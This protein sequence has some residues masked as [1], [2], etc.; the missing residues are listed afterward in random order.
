MKVV[1]L[2]FLVAS[3]LSAAAYSIRTVEVFNSPCGPSLD[4]VTL[5][6][7]LGNTTTC[8]A[9]GSKILFVEKLYEIRETPSRNFFMV[10]NARDLLL[11]GN[12]SSV[13]CTTRPVGFAF[14]NVTNI[15]IRGLSFYGCG[16]VMP[17]LI[18]SQLHL[19]SANESA[20]FVSRGTQV[21]LLFGNANRLTLQS[22]S[23]CDSNGYG[24]VIVDSLGVQVNDSTFSRNNRQ[25][26]KCI[27]L[28]CCCGEGN[29]NGGNIVLI[30]T[31]RALSR[32]GNEFL[33]VNNTRITHGV[34]LDTQQ[35]FNENYAYTA[36][37][38]SIFSDHSLYN[39]SIVISHCT[40]A[41]NIGHSSGNAVIYI[42]DNIGSDYRINIIRTDFLDGNT[43]FERFQK[44]AKSGGLTIEYGYVDE[45]RRRTTYSGD[46]DFKR[47]FIQHST[48]RGNM[49]FTAGALLF[50]SHIVRDKKMNGIIRF[51]NC[52]ISGNFGYD[53]IITAHGNLGNRFYNLDLMMDGLR[54]LQNRI[55]PQV[56]LTDP[57]LAYHHFPHISSLHTEE[58]ST[59]TCRDIVI[60]GNELRGL[61]TIWNTQFR[62]QQENVISD[63]RGTEGGAIYVDSSLIR[64]HRSGARINIINNTATLSGG[65]IYVALAPPRLI[66][67]EQ[68]YCFFDVQ[69]GQCRELP[70]TLRGSILLRNNTAGVSGNS[71]YGGKVG[72]CML[73]ECFFEI[74]PNRLA[75]ISVFEIVF[76]LP[77]NDSLTEVTSDIEGLCFCIGGRPQ[78]D[79]RTWS[80][81]AYPG[82]RVKVPA[83][84]VGQLN[85]TNPAIVLSRVYGLNSTYIAEQE[86]RQQVGVDCQDLNY[87]IHS[88]ESTQFEI[89]LGVIT[90]GRV[91]ETDQAIV[92]NTTEC[93]KGFELMESQQCSC[94][95]FLQEHGVS[96]IL[97]E[98]S[99]KR[100]ADVWLRY[101]LQTG[102]F[103]AH[104]SCPLQKCTSE[105]L[106]LD[107]NSS[108]SPCHSEFSGILCGRCA[109]GL[110]ATLG[111][112]GC[113]KCAGGFSALVVLIFVIA[114]PLLI[115]AM[116]YGDLTV[117]HGTFNGIIFYANIVHIHR[118][119]LFGPDHS[120]PVTVLLAWLNL[121]LGIE[122]CFYPGM[123]FYAQMWFQFSFPVYILLLV[124]ILN[125]LNWYTIL[126]G[127]I[128]G[129]NIRSVEATLV[130]LSYTKLLRLAAKTLSYTA[131]SSSNGNKYKLWLYDGNLAFM[132]SKHAILAVSALAILIF[133]ILPF[134]LLMLLEYP[135]L[136]HKTRR[137]LVKS[138][139]YTSIHVFQ[140]PYN[141]ITR[142]WTG[143]LLLVRIL[144]V[145]FHQVNVVGGQELNFVIIVT[146]GLCGLGTMWNFGSLYRNKYVTA[147]ETFYIMNLVLLAGW[148][149][150]V[151][152]HRSQLILSYTLVTLSLVVFLSTIVYHTGAK[153]FRAVKGRKEIRKA[154]LGNR[155]ITMQLV[156]DSDGQAAG[157]AS[158][159]YIR[160]TGDQT[161]LSK[162]VGEGENK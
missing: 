124:L 74:T 34:N 25:V 156:E 21:A 76:D 158:H 40:V 68:T 160:V 110:S 75:G 69:Y 78:C 55:L 129:N 77:W 85:G 67:Q 46:I 144:L 10:V 89:K 103:L 116:L 128:I 61:S 95:S 131:I 12:N 33:V 143:V 82:M 117:N 43:R 1:M 4:C 119:I 104:K 30:N 102:E 36:G 42:H 90:N 29:C 24:V 115:A 27:N 35:N 17:D 86:V 14:I 13:T 142:W 64:L 31:D 26:L 52:S 18:Q 108:D 16:A 81:K 19:A 44:T 62:F 111:R 23:V 72:T 79:L 37:G 149:E 7:C 49:A 2:R 136:R 51:R 66:S 109:S 151:T 99:F 120:S 22:T 123:T 147:L 94:T 145:T 139:I 38:L 112:I 152:T 5:S 20:F 135:L 100:P 84:A 63:N 92:V 122:M 161:P 54:V 39:L 60:Q 148:S 32:A 137:L 132:G 97:E 87:A 98:Q 58:I 107:L 134:T 28:T 6:E 154:R 114:G 57:L 15:Q 126:G 125:C 83:V 157:H 146:L 8:F 9:T 73:H 50:Q 141:E 155:P 45:K 70:T 88:P 140:M 71:V 80:L 96:C 59:V 56:S 121:D 162:M 138:G 91:F 118:S 159:T 153:V 105:T 127:R 130:L 47:V 65:A 3:W 150:Y 53:T 133:F 41:S 113:K 11:S 101:D 48:F 106:T 93:P